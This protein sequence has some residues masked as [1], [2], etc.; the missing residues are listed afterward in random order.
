[1]KAG[2]QNR[3]TEG[4]RWQ[5]LQDTASPCTVPSLGRSK[6]TIAS[7]GSCSQGAAALRNADGSRKPAVQKLV[8]A[9]GAALGADLPFQGGKPVKLWGLR[10]GKAAPSTPPRGDQGSTWPTPP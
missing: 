5:R 7:P 8:Q 9:G 2:S 1:M 4:G 10:C 6:E 3:S